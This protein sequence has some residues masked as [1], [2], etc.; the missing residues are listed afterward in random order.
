MAKM[1]NWCIFFCDL[2]FKV[3]QIDARYQPKTVYYPRNVQNLMP[4]SKNSKQSWPKIVTGASILCDLP[5]K[6]QEIDAKDQPKT[7]QQ[8]RN[9]QNTVPFTQTSKQSWPKCVLGAS[10]FETCLSK[11][12][13]LMLRINLKPYSSLEMSK[14]WCPFLKPVNSHGQ[15]V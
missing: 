8:P 11:Y 2:P 10:F 12:Y 3:Q 4:F 9:V 14:I 13:R 5:F 1:C 7:I 15:K 6:V